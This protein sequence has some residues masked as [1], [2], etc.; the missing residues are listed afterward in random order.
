MKCVYVWVVGR[1][2]LG[3]DDKSP[4]AASAPSFGRRAG[5]RREAWMRND[6]AK[7]Q[8]IAQGIGV[9]V[10]VQCNEV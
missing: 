9:C 3:I 1:S 6:E 7:T 5:A 10:N 2:V 4:R 8:G